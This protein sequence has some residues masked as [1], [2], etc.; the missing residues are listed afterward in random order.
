MDKAGLTAQHQWNREVI[1]VFFGAHARTAIAVATA[2]SGLDC[3]AKNW[4]D[5]KITGLPS[6][7][8][9]QLNRPYHEKYLDCTYNISEA[10][11]L[12]LRRGF[13]PWSMYK[14]GVYKKYL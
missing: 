2:E 8:I 5:A 7:G 11:K 1:S 4:E 12:F 3:Q 10:H 13:Q 14:N 9:F 6:L